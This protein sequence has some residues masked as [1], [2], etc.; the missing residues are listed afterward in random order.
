MAKVYI[1]VKP[2]PGNP[3]PSLGAFNNIFKAFSELP[4]IK[5]TFAR[6]LKDGDLSF[7]FADQNLMHWQQNT[8]EIILPFEMINAEPELLFLNMA[9][10]LYVIVGSKDAESEA[11]LMFLNDLKNA[12][13]LFKDFAESLGVD[14]KKYA[15]QLAA[16]ISGQRLN[17]KQ[18]QLLRFGKVY[19]DT[20]N[21]EPSKAVQIN[22]LLDALWKVSAFRNLVNKAIIESNYPLSIYF[23]DKTLIDGQNDLEITGNNGCLINKDVNL[24]DLTDLLINFIVKSADNTD[25]ECSQFQNAQSYGLAVLERSYKVSRDVATIMANIYGSEFAPAVLQVVAPHIIDA[26]AVKLTMNKIFNIY[27]ALSQKTFST[28]LIENEGNYR[29]LLSQYEAWHQRTAHREQPRAYTASYDYS[30]QAEHSKAKD[31]VPAFNILKDYIEKYKTYACS[32]SKSYSHCIFPG[33]EAEVQERYRNKPEHILKAEA[34]ANATMLNPRTF[35]YSHN[36]IA[37][38]GNLIDKAKSG[39]CTTLAIS[40]LNTLL[41]HNPQMRYQ[42]VASPV[43]EGTAHCFLLVADQ[44]GNVLIVDPWLASLGW[45]GVFTQEDYPFQDYF[46]NLECYFDSNNDVP[47]RA[48]LTA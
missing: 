48:K 5:A 20:Q 47:A 36:A 34:L 32:D 46:S 18:A 27:Q 15:F 22:R 24:Y 23:V 13:A 26:A 16:D 29:Q 17:D 9:T 41:I 44:Q 31:T 30:R 14:F 2:S 40:A 42:L 35:Q 25:I 38:V 33:K 43:V 1:N 6:I 39:C 3:P 45:E 28:Y 19:F 4:S 8:R 21:V 11:N 37:R 10:M 7:V 12:P